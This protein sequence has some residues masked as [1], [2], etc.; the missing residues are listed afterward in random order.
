VKLHMISV[1]VRGVRHVRFIAFPVG[2]RPYVPDWLYVE[3]NV[4]RGETVSHG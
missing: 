4:Q 1:T 2:V 3:L